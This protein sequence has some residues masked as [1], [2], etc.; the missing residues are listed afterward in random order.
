M[1]LLSIK[2]KIKIFYGR[3]IY[4]NYYICSSEPTLRSLGL[5]DCG[6]SN[7]AFI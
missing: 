5:A 7:G 6:V 2:S 1:A 4:I 3:L